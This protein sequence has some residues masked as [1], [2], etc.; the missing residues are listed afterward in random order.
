MSTQ[1]SDV[2]D[3][4]TGAFLAL[5]VAK[6]MNCK[7]CQAPMPEWIVDASVPESIR[8]GQGTYRRSQDFPHFSRS[9][10]QGKPV[11]T[12][13]GSRRSNS[14]IPAKHELG[15]PIRTRAKTEL[16]DP[17]DAL[18][19]SLDLLHQDHQFGPFA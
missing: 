7:R 13:I 11:Q 6:G 2:S 8:L 16:G 17:E 1:L 9:R 14:R 19:R 4:D 18:L 5:G 3:D 12:R 10:I 15:D